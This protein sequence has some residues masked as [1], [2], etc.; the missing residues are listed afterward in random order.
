MTGNNNTY[1]K[2]LIFSW[3]MTLLL[4]LGIGGYSNY[5]SPISFQENIELVVSDQQSL[6]KVISL[7]NAFNESPYFI[8]TSTLSSISK[9]H[10]TIAS[11][12][13]KKLDTIISSEIKY[14][15][16]FHIPTYSSEEESLFV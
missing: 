14:H 7:G 11:I 9:H 3:F 4:F 2:K 13:Y 16:L 12:M 6:V 8:T 15:L 5:T 10:E 1:N